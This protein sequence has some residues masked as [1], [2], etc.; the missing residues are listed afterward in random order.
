M[1]HQKFF[2]AGKYI[3]GKKYENFSQ[4]LKYSEKRGTFE[5]RG[6]CIIGFG[7]WKPWK[8]MS[9]LSMGGNWKSCGGGL[10]S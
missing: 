4:T 5:I 3:F 1:N 6:K 2:V 8:F 9:S 10:R 7:G